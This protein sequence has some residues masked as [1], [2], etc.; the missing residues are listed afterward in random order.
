M[1]MRREDEFRQS[2]AKTLQH[3]WRLAEL[4][5]GAEQVVDI[6]ESELQ[7]ALRERRDAPAL[8]DAP[9]PA[10]S[11]VEGTSHGKGRYQ[12]KRARLDPRNK[13]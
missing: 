5:G 4:T 2:L 3:L 1:A 8:R 9:S 12:Y 6:V 7:L 11:Q 10:C 13:G